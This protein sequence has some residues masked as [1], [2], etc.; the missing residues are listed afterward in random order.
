MYYR[1]WRRPEICSGPRKRVRENVYIYTHTHTH[2]HMYID[3]AYILQIYNNR[4]KVFEWRKKK[5][6]KIFFKLISIYLFERVSR[7][8][9]ALLTTPIPFWNF[10]RLPPP[11]CQ[12]GINISL[13]SGNSHPH[14]CIISLHFG[15]TLLKLS[16]P[17]EKCCLLL[18]YSPTLFSIVAGK[19]STL[20]TCGQKK[21]IVTRWIFFCMY[22]SEALSFYA[23]VYKSY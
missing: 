21:N 11:E 14:T 7:Y 22:T 13:S 4:R 9:W 16:E 12:Y 19:S 5:L 1:L 15:I 20:L 8:I 10:K 2:T 23:S 18:D 3:Y 17:F 6:G